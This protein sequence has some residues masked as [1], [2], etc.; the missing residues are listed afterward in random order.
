MDWTSVRQAFS[1]AP[2]SWQ[3]RIVALL[4]PRD[5]CRFTV[6]CADLS[7][8]KED[9]A[10]LHTAEHPHRCDICGNV[11]CHP[12][13][14]PDCGH[15]ACGRCIHG[16]VFPHRFT[17]FHGWRCQH[18]SGDWKKSCGVAVR[19]RP[20]KLGAEY[21][22]QEDLDAVVDAAMPSAEQ[23]EQWR[24]WHNSPVHAGTHGRFG[25]AWNVFDGA[26]FP[27]DFDE[28]PSADYRDLPQILPAGNEYTLTI[29]PAAVNFSGFPPDNVREFRRGDAT[30]SVARVVLEEGVCADDILLVTE[31]RGWFNEYGHENQDVVEYV[32]KGWEELLSN[33]GGAS[34]EESGSDGESG[35]SE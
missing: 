1:T 3:R 20:E 21:C 2:F 34:E 25:G 27:G 17:D 29:C 8:Q 35:M 28:T 18:P 7:E 13:R 24:A 33:D 31:A 14:L 19:R 11:L 6:C 10:E 22:S 16:K 9:I 23:R 32:V 30:E 15:V 4:Q 5:A 12:H 26:G